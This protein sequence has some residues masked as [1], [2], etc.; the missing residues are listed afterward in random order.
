MGQVEPAGGIL[1]LHV[2]TAITVPLGLVAAL[3]VLYAGLLAVSTRR[4]TDRRTRRAMALVVSGGRGV[5]TVTGV[6]DTGLTVRGDPRVQIVMAVEP[7]EGGPALERRK[8]VTVARA[9]I[10]R[11]GDRFP[12]WYDRRDPSDWAFGTDVEAVAPPE[13]QD[14]FARARRGA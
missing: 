11:V 6:H 12:V 14:L 5:G 10:P 4:G 1:A 2:P 13:V 3:A 9:A 8:T 7:V